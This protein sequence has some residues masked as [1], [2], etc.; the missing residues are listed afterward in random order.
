VKGETRL[1]FRN[2]DEPR[3]ASIRTYKRLGGYQALA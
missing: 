1:L 2:I 3:L